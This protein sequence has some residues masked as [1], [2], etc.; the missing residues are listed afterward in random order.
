M[1]TTVALVTLVVGASSTGL[2]QSLQG[3]WKPV[4][5]V[6]DGRLPVR[7]SEILQDPVSYQ[8][9]V[10]SIRELLKM[11]VVPIKGGAPDAK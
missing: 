10:S 7:K 1:R 4:E 11:M 8:Q 9:F 5:V 2:G 6:V 3:T